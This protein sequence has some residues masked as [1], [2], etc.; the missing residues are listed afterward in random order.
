MTITPLT[1]ILD[2]VGSTGLR[3]QTDPDDEAWYQFVQ[4]HKLEIAER[5]ERISVSPNELTETRY[6]LER[7]L[8]RRDIDR[9]YAWVVRVIN[10]RA[11][12]IEFTNISEL[13]I[14]NSDYMRILYEQYRASDV[15]IRREAP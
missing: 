13:L 11:N 7:F 10:P 14:P 8:R 15:V 6:N 9:Q 1:T 3:W 5:A 2:A 4:D 12:D